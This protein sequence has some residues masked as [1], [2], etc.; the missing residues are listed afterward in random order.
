[1]LKA[2]ACGQVPPLKML[3]DRGLRLD[4][5]EGWHAENALLCSA[6]QGGV[7]MLEFLFNSGF[8]VVP[9]RNDSLAVH[10]AINR[11]DINALQF[12]LVKK[13]IGLPASEALVSAVESIPEKNKSTEATQRMLD[14]LLDHGLDINASKD[15]DSGQTC[16]WGAIQREDSSFLRLLLDRS[17]SPMLRDRQGD[18]PLYAAAAKGFL[19]GVRI[20]LEWATLHTQNAEIITRPELRA[21][22]SN[23]VLQAAAQESWK[24]VRILERYDYTGYL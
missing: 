17:A 16:L 3:L 10:T 7:P 2:L 9:E 21:Q 20:I 14:I 15:D 19:E 23:A 6:A 1:M 22:I 8:Q 12:L 24:I 13:K 5:S 11:P 4:V 18:T